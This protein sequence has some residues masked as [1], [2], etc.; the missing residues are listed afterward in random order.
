MVKKTEHKYLW[1]N[2]IG[3]YMAGMRYD[4]ATEQRRDSS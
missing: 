2:M 1:R 4:E 3:T